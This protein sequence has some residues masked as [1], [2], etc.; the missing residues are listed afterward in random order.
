MSK[1]FKYTARFSNV[2]LASGEIDSP[3]LNISKASLDSL[4]GIIPEDV[5]LD[6]NIVGSCIQCG[7]SK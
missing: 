5:D 4:R 2:L 3:K 6:K 1:E 7:P